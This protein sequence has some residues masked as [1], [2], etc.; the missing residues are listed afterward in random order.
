MHGR[1]TA[2]TISVIARRGLCVIGDPTLTIYWSYIYSSV[3]VV[4]F[5]LV[6]M[7]TF[8]FLTYRNMRSLKRTAELSNADSQLA[9]MVFLQ[10]ILALIATFPYGS[11]N[12]YALATA[13]MVKSEEQATRDVFIVGVTTLISISHFGVSVRYIFFALIESVFKSVGKLLR[14]PRGVESLSR[15]MQAS[16]SLFICQRKKGPSDK[17]CLVTG[18]YASGTVA[19]PIIQAL[20]YSVMIVVRYLLLLIFNIRLVIR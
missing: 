9:I 17:H 14:I 10:V 11:Y 8:G 20:L 18:F 7:T 3:V 12:V 16:P 19:N 2:R 15:K 6:T 5:P 4:T 1:C 13:N